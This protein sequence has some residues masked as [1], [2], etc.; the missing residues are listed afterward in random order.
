[1]IRKATQADLSAI[2]KLIDWGAS[3]GRVLPRSKKELTPIIESFYI[4]IDK[5]TVVGC[6]S[7]EIYS[8]KLA[9]IRSL[10]VLDT[11]Q[12][13]GIGRKLTEACLKEAKKKKVYELLTI[14]DKHA[15]FDR[16][17]FTT[18]LNGQYAMFMRP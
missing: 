5:D 1:M 7:L 2:K 9:E 3:V 14:T 8:K 11:H 13:Q 4:W 10:V 16:L 17:G 12:K 18:C 15:F 6:C